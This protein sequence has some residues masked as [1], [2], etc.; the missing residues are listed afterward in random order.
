MTGDDV[1]LG[2]SMAEENAVLK[3]QSKINTHAANPSGENRT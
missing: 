1:K 3:L 2:K